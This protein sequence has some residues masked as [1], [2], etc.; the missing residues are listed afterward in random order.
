VKLPE[1]N[2]VSPFKST[3]RAFVVWGFA[4]SLSSEAGETVGLGQSELC[5][6]P[7]SHLRNFLRLQHANVIA[8]IDPAFLSEQTPHAHTIQC[9]SEDE[10]EAEEASAADLEGVV[11][12][13]G[14]L[15]SFASFA[16]NCGL[17]ML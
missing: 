16:R 4:K 6:S 1:T 7:Q 3:V 5:S 15:S 12:E 9:L 17:M 13:V 14:L 10:A 11:V 2:H 8:G